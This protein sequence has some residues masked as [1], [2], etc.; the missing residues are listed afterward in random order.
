M[1][2]KILK[3]NRKKLN[4][5]Q[6]E[7]SMKLGIQQVR[8]SYYES[9]RN[10]PKQDFFNAYKRVFGVD[11]LITNDENSEAI[12]L[13]ENQESYKKGAK[14]GQKSHRENT[15]ISTKNVIELSHKDEVILNLSRSNKIMAE[16]YLEQASA[17]NKQAAANDK[18]SEAN[19]LMVE[20]MPN[21]NSHASI[22]TEL[23]AIATRKHFVELLS[24]IRTK[25]DPSLSIEEVEKEYN[26]MLD[27][28]EAKDKEVYK[29]SVSD[30]LHKHLQD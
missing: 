7:M 23:N 4:L 17:N 16:A 11:L 15:Q 24:L 21:I 18:Q 5:S 1:L 20:K 26:N 14:K 9:G 27:D 28:I 22:E 13:A 2:P 6:A 25:D 29:K 19:R 10:N 12:F 30:K 3:E 8:Y